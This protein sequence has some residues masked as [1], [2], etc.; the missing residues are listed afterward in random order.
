MNKN[1]ETNKNFSKTNS[2]LNITK[3]EKVEKDITET[4]CSDIN[5]NAQHVDKDIYTIE[6]IDNNSN[7]EKEY[8][9][10]SKTII[11]N[12]ES[13]N[14][15]N[16]LHIDKNVDSSEN[17]DIDSVSE[18]MINIDSPGSKVIDSNNVKD[19]VSDSKTVI[20]NEEPQKNND[21]LNIEEKKDP[22]DNKGIDSV[23]KKDTF[24]DSNNSKM[25]DIHQEIKSSSAVVGSANIQNLNADKNIKNYHSIYNNFFGNDSL[26]R[27]THT[28]LDPTRPLPNKT[29]ELNT[30]GKFLEIDKFLEKLIKEQILFVSCPDEKILLGAVYSMIEK[31]EFNEYE[32]RM[33]SFGKKNLLNHEV[34]LD[35]II[36]EKIGNGDKLIIIIDLTS[37][38][39]L[40]SM[41]CGLL[42]SKTIQ[43]ELQER[44]ILL[45]CMIKLQ[46]IYDFLNDTKSSN[47]ES[48]LHYP[49]W[50]ISFLPHLLNYYFSEPESLELKEKILF[51][52][53][54]GLWG[55]DTDFEFYNLIN[56]FL[57]SEKNT[58]IKE[59][60]KRNTFKGNQNPQ[61]F[62]ESI[63]SVNTEDFVFNAKLLNKII[64]FIITYFPKIGVYEFNSLVLLL[65]SDETIYE[66]EERISENG[67]IIK[68][69]VERKLESIWQQ[70]YNQ[71]LKE[72]YV[73]LVYNQ[74]IS[75]QGGEKY[76]DFEIPYLRKE[77]MLVLD[78]LLTNKLF[79]KIEKSGLLFNFD[80][81]QNFIEH[82]IKL[83]TDM[84]KSD[85]DYYGVNWLIRLVMGIIQQFNIKDVINSDNELELIFRF[86]AQKEAQ[87]IRSVFI[88]RL[89]DLIRDMWKYPYLQ[90]NI[91]Q[92]LRRLIQL[93][94][95]GVALE[96][97]LGVAKSLKF[98]F[99]F[100]ALSWVKQIINQ[101]NEE[102][103]IKAYNYL[104]NEAKQSG[105]KI[106]DFL[107]NVRDW[108]PEH[109]K[110]FENCS[111]SSKLIL[112][113]VWTYLVDLFLKFD[114]KEYGNFLKFPIFSAVHKNKYE[115]FH[116][117]FELLFQFI[118]HPIMEHIINLQ[119]NNNIEIAFDSDLKPSIMMTADLIE[120][121]YLI[122]NSSNNIVQDDLTSTFS[123][124]MLKSIEKSASKSQKKGLKKSWSTKKRVYR[125]LLSKN[126]N[127]KTKEDI[128]HIKDRL[129]KLKLLI[130][131][132]KEL[133]N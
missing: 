126:S 107:Y 39:F 14:N 118:F 30:F 104:Y 50:N 13:E 6:S 129:T 49:V 31:S 80:V 91:N 133:N 52:K 62:I 85:P 74:T 4:E 65:I 127:V 122:I 8:D 10:A 130:R 61:V 100:N 103:R 20:D 108:L 42:E 28:F 27:E 109:N 99:Q 59:I 115:L 93:K 83:S 40:D 121:W 98:T 43:M 7:Q 106:Y 69:K 124:A 73:K 17:K 23:S 18:K 5:N 9:Y 131:N 128:K 67:T 44:K 116:K 12:E 25:T 1:D 77:L 19:T 95:H 68:Q 37:Q 24:N 86:L 88:A 96:I 75:S 58:L 38:S 70:N 76:Y 29:I 112:L 54:N 63:K 32:K 97:V 3:N 22:H 101:G 11:G 21:A 53:R 35:T 81:S 51:Q 16:T 132:Y 105:K 48:G 26:Q 15:N 123:I 79:S 90:D 102:T 66:D 113:L 33:L 55:E 82:I 72:C 111:H 84:A 119:L 78:P 57:Q 56:G 41:L 46:N 92:F 64:L 45:I 87:K 36:N 94:V 110:E 34:Y 117:N 114:Y 60:E 125:Q 47:I 89:S 2:N 71:V 120:G